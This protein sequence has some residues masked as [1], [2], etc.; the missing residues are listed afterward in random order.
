M[1]SIPQSLQ[2]EKDKL[3]QSE[4]LTFVELLLNVGQTL[5]LALADEDIT[6]DGQLYEKWN[7]SLS[8]LTENTDGSIDTIEFSVGNVSREMQSFVEANNGLRGNKLTVKQ[9]YRD[10]LD[11]VAAFVSEAY[12]INSAN[13]IE[14]A[15][16]F[17]CTSKYDQAGVR[18]PLSRASRLHCDWEYDDVDT[19]DW[20]NQSGALDTSGFPL[21]DNTTCDKGLNTPNGCKAHLN[22]QR[23]RMFQ[24]IPEGQLYV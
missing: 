10:L 4:L 6:Y 9:V 16:N 17:A 7:L 18:L 22:S 11:D 15:I 14:E 24:G 1:K 8:E 5:Y 3:E 21:A 23:P 12:Y 20:T 13:C 2:T 19:C